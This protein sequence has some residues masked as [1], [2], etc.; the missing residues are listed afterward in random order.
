MTTIKSLRRE[1]RELRANMD[2]IA[3]MAS[4]IAKGTSKDPVRTAK[5]IQ[6]VAVFSLDDGK[7]HNK[8]K[9]RCEALLEEAERLGFG[10]TMIRK[11]MKEAKP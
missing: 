9:S 3:E 10:V 8:F 6:I 5:A 1:I 11:A 2:C 4:W 7:K